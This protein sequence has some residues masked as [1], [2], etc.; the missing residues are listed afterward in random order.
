MANRNDLVQSFLEAHPTEAA[1]ILE[2]MDG[3]IVI[4]LF[5]LL[6]PGPI[7]V[8]VDRM[9]P[10]FATDLMDR[11]DTGL[12][13]SIMEGIPFRSLAI[14][15]RRMKSK[16]AVLEGLPEDLVTDLRQVDRFPE[17]TVGAR[18]DPRALTVT[19]D[20]H[21]DEVLA[22][23]RRF[24]ERVKENLYVIDRE[25]IL[26]GLCMM[27]RLLGS[28]SDSSIRTVMGSVG[29]TLS[30]Y[31]ALKSA[32]RAPGW[33]SSRE[34]P[35]VDGE[36]GFLGSIGLEDVRGPAGSESDRDHDSEEAL[37]DL[38]RLGF[39]SFMKGLHLDAGRDAGKAW[40]G[41]KEETENE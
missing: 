27:N 7:A 9:N 8:V 15:L 10:V 29:Q 38:Y 21:V 1:R 34:M 23:G 11:I 30:P 28:L 33:Q 2:Q 40:D 24:P 20:L 5:Q 41:E 39:A 36:G 32:S 25:R 18:M 16:E 35:V 37:G 17:G 19:D 26:V 31:M 4:G 22:A 13:I 14:L 6:N 12:A 3:N